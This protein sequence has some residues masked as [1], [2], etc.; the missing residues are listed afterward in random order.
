MTWFGISQQI[1]ANTVSDE[2]ILETSHGAVRV[3]LWLGEL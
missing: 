1:I 2:K 3:Q